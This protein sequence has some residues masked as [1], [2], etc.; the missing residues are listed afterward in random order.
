MD[1][2]GC[3]YSV[4]KAFSELDL[5]VEK[6]DSIKMGYIFENLIARFYQ[7]VEAGQFYTGRDIIRL[8]VSLLLA[9]GSEDIT[10]DNKVITV[11]DQDCGT[12]GLL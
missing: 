1:K 7:N 9:E 11:L 6:F 12:G 5:S 3:L 4:V 8:C 10:E 2:G